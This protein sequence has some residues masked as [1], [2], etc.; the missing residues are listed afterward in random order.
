MATIGWARLAGHASVPRDRAERRSQPDTGGDRPG[1]AISL[2]LLAMLVFTVMDGLSKKL[3]VQGMSPELVASARYLLVLIFLAPVLA[4]AWPDRPLHTRQP[5]LHILRGVLLIA[6][7]TLF[8]YAVRVLPLETA[9][10]IGFVSPLFVT[11]LSILFLGE[12][13]GIRRWGAIAVGFFGVILILRPGTDVF[14]PAM[15][16]PML[17]S[18]CWAGGLIITRAMRGKERAFTVLLWSTGS[19]FVVIAPFGLADWQMPDALQWVLLTL[20]A[21]CHVA[22]QYLTIRAFMLASASLL[23][24]FSYTTIIWA[25]LIGLFA[26]DSLP[27]LPTVAGTFV[28]AAAGLYVWHRERLVTGQPT[29]PGNSIAEAAVAIPAIAMDGRRRDDTA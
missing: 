7:A 5:G 13:V 4:R 6:S 29:V 21:L 20:V 23:A 24:P 18:L 14:T 28:L 11:A 1:H 15:L 2:F 3:T 12:K 27:D 16:L 25:T 9:T 8:I 19:G 10:A 17:S 26:F 22:G